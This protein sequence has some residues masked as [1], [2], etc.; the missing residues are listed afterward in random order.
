[1]RPRRPAAAEA[2]AQPGTGTALASASGWAIA[3]L[4]GAVAGSPSSRSGRSSCSGVPEGRRAVD[5]SLPVQLAGH[6]GDGV[7]LAAGRLRGRRHPRPPGARFRDDD[8]Q[9]QPDRGAFRQPPLRGTDLG[10]LKHPLRRQLRSASTRTRPGSTTASGSRRPT[11]RTGAPST[12]SCTTSTR[13]TSTPA[14]AP[15]AST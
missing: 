9:V 1:M 15:R 2:A 11:R 8:G 6:G 12:R 3:A 5:L 14:A 13:A 7:Q 4:I 10:R